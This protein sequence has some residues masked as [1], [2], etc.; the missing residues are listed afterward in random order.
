[1]NGTPEV[2]EISEGVDSLG[3]SGQEEEIWWKIRIDV[4]EYQ[5]G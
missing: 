2:I 4:G 5:L 3:W 1:M